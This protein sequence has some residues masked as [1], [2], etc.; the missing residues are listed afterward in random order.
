MDREDAELIVEKIKQLISTNRGMTIPQLV[1]ELKDL[2]ATFIRYHVDTMVKKAILIKNK[3]NGGKE[4]LYTV[5]AMDNSPLENYIVETLKVN[6]TASMN[7]KDLDHY[8]RF[9]F[10]IKEEFSENDLKAILEKFLATKAVIKESYSNN[11]QIFY[12][13]CMNP[14]YFKQEKIVL[15]NT[16]GD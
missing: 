14:T 16:A 8:I 15:S 5:K 10:K 3:G 2:K 4:M 13:Y 6:S 12:R 9:Y 11:N 1:Y 7:L